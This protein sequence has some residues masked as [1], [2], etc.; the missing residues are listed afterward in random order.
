[1]KTTTIMIDVDE[2]KLKIRVQDEE[3]SFNVFEAMK[4]P[5]DQ[6]DCLRVGVLDELDWE[7]QRKLSDAKPLIKAIINNIEDVN[8]WD[9]KEVKD[10]LQVLDKAK[11]VYQEVFEDP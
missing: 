6:K 7:N 4:H 11:E 9:E 10:F 8:E 2:G 3:V 5:G 1:M